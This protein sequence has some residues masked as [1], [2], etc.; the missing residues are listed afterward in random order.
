MPGVA[1]L[2]SLLYILSYLR[3]LHDGIPLLKLPIIHALLT[4]QGVIPWR[5]RPFADS[6]LDRMLLRRVDGRYVF[7]HPLL[8]EYIYQKL[9]H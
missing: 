9:V 3:R 1:I 2:G 8:Q 5:F 4:S 7:W 6:A